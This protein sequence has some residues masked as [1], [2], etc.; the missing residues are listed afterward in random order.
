MTQDSTAFSIDGTSFRFSA[1]LEAGLELGGYVRIDT[2]EGAEYLGQILDIELELAGS[3]GRRISGHG[4]IRAAM[5][6]NGTSFGAAR[7]SAANPKAVKAHF[8]KKRGSKAG[9][10]IGAMRRVGVPPLKWSTNWGRF[11]PSI[12]GP[13]DGWEAREAGRHRDEAAAG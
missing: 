6:G 2:G 7:V 4:E 13:G 1:T 9:L 12:G 10:E 5:H 8:D 11:A 3:G